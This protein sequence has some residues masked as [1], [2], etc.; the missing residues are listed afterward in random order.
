MHNQ[1][2]HTMSNTERKSCQNYLPIASNKESC[3][4]S[5]M[6]RPLRPIAEDLVYHVEKSPVIQDDDHL[7]TV[8][9]YIEANPLRAGI[10]D[11][12]GAYRWSSF[13]DHGA[14]RADALLSPIPAYESLGAGAAARRRRWSAYVHASS[15]LSNG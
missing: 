10:V 9:R 3:W 7:L 12:A 1:N 5:V 15:G 4:N 6:P 2:L 13:G 8:L 11:D 14:G